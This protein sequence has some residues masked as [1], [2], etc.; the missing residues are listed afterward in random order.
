MTEPSDACREQWRA[1]VCK[2]AE[3]ALEL[4]EQPAQL[5]PLA[6]DASDDDRRALIL[7][8]AITM[9]GAAV[10]KLCS[11][12]G[13]PVD[14]MDHAIEGMREVRKRMESRRQHVARM[15]GARS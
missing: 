8:T 5:E 15:R 4:A 6:P 14:A 10:G 13:R 11:D 3:Q 1:A 9:V 12:A 7:A 2:L